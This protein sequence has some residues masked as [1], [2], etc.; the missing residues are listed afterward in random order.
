MRDIECI[1]E[2][3]EP[4]SLGAS[5]F[6]GGTGAGNALSRT[7]GDLAGPMRM[8][9]AAARAACFSF[10]CWRR[11][12]MKKTKTAAMIKP[13]TKQAIAIPTT[14]PAARPLTTSE[15]DGALAVGGTT[16][17]AT[18]AKTVCAFVTVKE[19]STVATASFKAWT[20]VV[21]LCVAVVVTM[22]V[23]AVVVIGT[24]VILNDTARLTSMISMMMRMSVAERPS[25]V[26]IDC[27]KFA[28]NVALLRTWSRVKLA[29]EI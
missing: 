2:A 9:G 15:L 16:G 23:A 7:A 20:M 13:T 8:L 24:T 3:L 18:G 25:A 21:G 19:G 17:A 26:A 4:D 1:S 27:F 12:R 29:E 28:S 11:R 5:S 14:G 10:C 6:G 22:V